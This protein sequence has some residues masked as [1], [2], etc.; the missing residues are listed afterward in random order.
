MQRID[1]SIFLHASLLTVR[2]IKLPQC[3]EI[4]GLLLVSGRHAVVVGRR[5]QAGQK[6]PLP[7]AQKSPSVTLIRE[8][9]ME[10]SAL[11]KIDVN[12]TTNSV[13]KK[14]PICATAYRPG[15]AQLDQP[16]GWGTT[17]R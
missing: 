9:E 5:P 4:S 14:K 15:T 17:R 7:D 2:C 12:S 8:S 13:G 3:I 6:P 16:L 1:I 11:P 10:I